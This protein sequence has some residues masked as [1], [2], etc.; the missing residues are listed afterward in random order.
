MIDIQWNYVV[1]KKNKN[2]WKK[3]KIIWVI[4]CLVSSSPET[5]ASKL[6]TGI[7]SFILCQVKLQV[8]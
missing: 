1:Q 7:E 2:D 3:L 5:L 8:S 6:E 4:M